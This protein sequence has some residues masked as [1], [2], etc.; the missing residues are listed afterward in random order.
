MDGAGMLEPTC[1]PLDPLPLSGKSLAITW[2][3]GLGLADE[4]S[5]KPA[6]VPSS[7]D[8]KGVEVSVH[9]ELQDV[10][11]NVYHRPK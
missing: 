10:I 2:M 6:R 9:I 4:T 5:G 1:G 11:R 8:R 3:G 7:I